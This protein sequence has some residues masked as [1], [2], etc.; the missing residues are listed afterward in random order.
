MSQG[1]LRTFVIALSGGFMLAAASSSVYAIDSNNR[2]FAYGLGQKTCDDYV[3]FRE[4]KLDALE[5]HPRYT[6]EELYEIVTK[7]IEQWVA[8][9]LTAHNLYVTDTDTYNVAAKVTMEDL[10]V[11]LETACRGN[12]KQY[13]AEAMISLVQQMNPERVKA[14]SAK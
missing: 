7:V 1:V 4:R 12:P 2:Y 9:F 10:E 14:E 8:G 5:Q 3:K 6:K 11:R 13:F